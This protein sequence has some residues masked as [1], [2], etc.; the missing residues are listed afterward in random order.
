MQTAHP[1]NP[2]FLVETP[3]LGAVIA[4][5]S[6]GGGPMAP[7]LSLNQE[8]MFKDFTFLGGSVSP[9]A[10]PTEGDGL[11]LIEHDYFGNDSQTRFEERYSL[12][13]RLD[14]GLR[15]APPVPVMA[16]HA[17]QYESARRMMF[18]DSIAAV[19][20][21]SQEEDERYGNTPLGRAARVARNTIQAKNGTVFVALTHSG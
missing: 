21:L 13:E 19:F 14:A 9:L 18:D 15:N 6:G 1:A 17:A 8:G 20:R 12:L 7:F 4:T 3:H 10:A 16:D 11:S 5:E 2:A